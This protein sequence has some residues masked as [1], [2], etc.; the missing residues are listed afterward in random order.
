MLVHDDKF[1]PD[2]LELNAVAPANIS[3]VFVHLLM[4]QLLSG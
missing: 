2:K 1:H 3:L 4:S